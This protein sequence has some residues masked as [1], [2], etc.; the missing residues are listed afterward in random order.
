M[1]RKRPLAVVLEQ[2]VAAADRRDV[3]VGVAVV[4]DVG[5]RGGDADLARHRDAGRRRDVLKLAA[6]GVLPQL[7]AADLVDEVDVGQAVAVDVRDRDAVAV[8]VVRRLVGLAGV[9]DD[10]V[11]EGD[12]AL[13][14]P[15]A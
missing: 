12:A 5:K 4:V 13:G 6:A 1:S 7:V 10:A 3:Q 9:V 2:H 15:I 8:V 11:L 14:Q